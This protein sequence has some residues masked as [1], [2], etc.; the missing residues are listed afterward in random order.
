MILMY[1]KFT[2]LTFGEFVIEKRQFTRM[3]DSWDKWHKSVPCVTNGFGDVNPSHEWLKG[4]SSILLFHHDPFLSS[5][6]TE[7]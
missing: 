4:F 6:A 5:I 3:T 1:S 7:S 2:A